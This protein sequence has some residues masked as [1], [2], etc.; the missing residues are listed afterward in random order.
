MVCG[1]EHMWGQMCVS[2]R[3]PVFPSAFWVAASLQ[4]VSHVRGSKW[5]EGSCVGNCSCESSGNGSCHWPTFSGPVELYLALGHG[6]WQIWL[7][8]IAFPQQWVWKVVAQSPMQQFLNFFIF[9]LLHVISREEQDTATSHIHLSAFG[10]CVMLE[11]ERDGQYCYTASG[12]TDGRRYHR[13]KTSEWVA[14]GW[15][16][17]EEWQDPRQRSQRISLSNALLEGKCLSCP[18]QLFV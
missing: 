9:C 6:L 1:S 14:S 4:A 12:C 15:G 16:C 10:T 8:S 17:A 18:W 2:S 13:E 3:N 7:K 5:S 11:K